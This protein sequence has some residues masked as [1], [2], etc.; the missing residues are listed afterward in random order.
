MSPGIQL[1]EQ[2]AIHYAMALLSSTPVPRLPISIQDLQP[3]QLIAILS[4][5]KI[6]QEILPTQ[7]L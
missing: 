7:A 1:Q 6:L 4:V 5:Q 2:Q 3:I